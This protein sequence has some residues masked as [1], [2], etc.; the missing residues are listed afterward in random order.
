MTSGAFADDA[1]AQGIAGLSTLKGLL[2]YAAVLTFA[3]L[4]TYFIVKISSAQSVPTFDTALT[5][6][7]AGLAGVLGSAFALEIG[8]ATDSQTT[9]QALSAALA[10]AHTTK[11]K[12]V[13]RVW[14]LFSI[15]R[16]SP[17]SPSWPK[18]FGIWVYALV[19]SAVAVT[20][21]L[22][23]HQTPDVIKALAVA[24]AGYI[25]ALVHSVYGS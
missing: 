11:E 24:F 9:N 4:Y 6:A 14:Q 13:A 2:L 17:A 16:T 23:E 7:A 19:A 3:G 12:L 18:T 5:T 1:P 10:N 22:N 21:V 20:Y 15:S 25:I 8:V